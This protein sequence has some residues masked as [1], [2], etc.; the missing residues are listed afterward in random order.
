MKR[1]FIFCCILIGTLGVAATATPAG[2]LEGNISSAANG[3]PLPEACILLQGTFYGAAADLSGNYVIYSVPAGEYRATVSLMGY[4]TLKNVPVTVVEGDVT[5]A[6]FQIHPT[7][8]KSEDV[9]ITA[10]RGPSLVQDVPSS[11]DVVTMEMI[12][13]ENPQNLAE[14]LDDVQGVYIKD[15]G[16]IGGMKTISL[17]GSSS[18]QVLVLIDGQRM[19]NAQNGQV[20]FGAVSVE[21]VERI[22]VVRGGNSALYGADAI[23]GVINIITKKP[24]DS[25]GVIVREQAMAGSF[26]SLSNET[27]IQLNRGRYSAELAYRILA[28]EGNYEYTDIYDKVKE[29]ANNDMTS[30]DVFARL[31]VKLA[32][33]SLHVPRNLDFSYKYYTSERG[34]P[35]GINAPYEHAYQE[36]ETHQL[37]S[38]FNTPLF[39]PLNNLNMQV[40]THYNK[41]HYFNQEMTAP[42][43]SW[44]YSSTLGG[45]SQYRQV[46]ATDFS[47][48]Y[49]AGFRMEAMESEEFSQDPDRSSS[50]SFL[51][52]ESMFFPRIMP[53][54]RS[55]SLI[56]AIRLDH[57][58]DFGTHISPKVGAVANFGQVLRTSL[59][60]NLGKSFRAPTFNDMYW[61]QDAFTV[62]NPDLQPEYGF[63][64]DV[65][66]RFRWPVLNDISVDATY[67]HNEMTDLII[68]A[69][70][71]TEMWMPNNVSKANLEGYE[72]GMTIHPIAELFILRGNYT[73]LNTTNLSEDPNENGNPL[74]YRPRHNLNVS[75]TFLWRTLSVA[76]THSYTSRRYYNASN[77]NLWLEPYQLSDVTVTYETNVRNTKAHIG[78]Q[79]KNIFDDRY[80]IVRYHPLPGR[81]FRVTLGFTFGTSVTNKEK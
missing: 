36:D 78:F 65:G 59:K 22:E 12:E 56:P 75:A 60:A 11:V 68:W 47:I 57:F 66:L 43:D 32:E 9:T 46:I 3:A 41:Y 80:E 64:W 19:N 81:E 17:R 23:G 13:R 15:Y 62:G 16:G 44:Y 14:V 39:G 1:S 55:I 4:E 71:E 10:T 38:S 70:D 77:P 73:L 18:G 61:P 30:N 67:F 7:A 40:Y 58:S 35:G 51:Q 42:A 26:S 79:A 69:S 37:N 6:D 50:F 63:D 20:D 48:M 28:S 24:S 21:G 34:S 33:T 74:V 54:L 72:I 2:V 29:R 76:Y 8:L 25:T 52:T 53:G 31:R 49:G 5:R 27:S 45:E